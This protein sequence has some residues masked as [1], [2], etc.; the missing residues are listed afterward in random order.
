MVS[1]LESFGAISPHMMRLVLSS[2]A[3]LDC[4]PDG[5]ATPDRVNGHKSQEVSIPLARDL[6]IIACSIVID[7]DFR[8][9]LAQV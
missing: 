7:P 1:T 8:A 4:L 9:H 5:H 3:R 2:N 6:H